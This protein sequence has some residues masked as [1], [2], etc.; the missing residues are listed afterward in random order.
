MFP[1]GEWEH[2]TGDLEGR[3][4]PCGVDVLSKK[5][6]ADLLIAG[7]DHFGLLQSDDG[8][9]T[10]KSLGTNDAS[11]PIENGPMSIVYD[12]DDADTYW[13]AGTYGPS[14]YRTTDAGKTF[15][16]LGDHEVVK[17]SDHVSVDF[18]DPERATLLAGTHENGNVL[19]L[20]RDSGETWENIATNEAGDQRFLPDGCNW[21]T[22]PHILDEDTFL[23]GC[24]TGIARS[25]D[26]G[27]TW[28]LVSDSGGASPPLVASDGSLYWLNEPGTQMLRSENLGKTWTTIEIPGGQRG[29]TT[30]P[31][32]LPDGRFATLG[33]ESVLIS[34]DDFETWEP[35]SPRYP[36]DLPG[37]PIGLLYSEPQNAFYIWGHHCVDEIEGTEIQKYELD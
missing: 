17:Q 24:T 37:P 12:P 10:W 8:G 11:D 7:F 29:R 1:E 22:L 26:G 2:A 30:G 20:S 6:G 14:P 18:N 13:E 19:F 27:E 5:P 36:S 9:E 31:L 32:E 33:R 25:E 21:S 34:S 28:E 3:S 4:I 23:L 15:V 16:L 35:G